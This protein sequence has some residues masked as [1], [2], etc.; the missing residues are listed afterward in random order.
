M[1]GDLN[2]N[3]FGWGKPSSLPKADFFPFHFIFPKK[4]PPFKFER[5]KKYLR[6]F[7]YAGLTSII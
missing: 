6:D 3:Y 1:T 7:L 2:Q 4:K 5:K